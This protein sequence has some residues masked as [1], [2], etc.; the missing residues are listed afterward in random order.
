MGRSPPLNNLS[1][2]YADTGDLERAIEFAG[3]A[4]DLCTNLGDRHR[5]AALH[6]NL[7][8]LYHAAGL[9]GRIHGSSQ[10]GGDYLCRGQ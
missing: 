8:D 4:L 5:E 7:A 9:E 6:N 1:L 10:K 3:Q 2:T